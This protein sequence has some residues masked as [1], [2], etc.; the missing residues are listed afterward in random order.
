MDHDGALMVFYSNGKG[1][2]I[3]L[4]DGTRTEFKYS[5]KGETVRVT[6]GNM[7][8]TVK[9]VKYSDNVIYSLLESDQSILKMVKRK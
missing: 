3:D 9:I 6:V 4:H 2:E 7:T 1:Y 5:I 8:E